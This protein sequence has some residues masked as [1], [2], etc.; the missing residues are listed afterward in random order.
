MLL[1]TLL[2]DDVLVRAVTFPDHRRLRETIDDFD[3]LKRNR[4]VGTLWF[5]CFPYRAKGTVG[6]GG[7]EA[8]G[9]PIG[10]E[11]VYVYSR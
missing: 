2:F 4:T 1:S 5:A 10:K 11:E 6:E 8:L 7:E 3:D 9:L